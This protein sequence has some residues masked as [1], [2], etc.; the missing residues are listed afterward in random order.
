MTALVAVDVDPRFVQKLLQ[1]PVHAAGVQHD[2][3]VRAVAE[4]VAA[5]AFPLLRRVL[6]GS[7]RHPE[8]STRRRTPASAQ[9]CTRQAGPPGFQAGRNPGLTFGFEPLPIDQSRTGTLSRPARFN[10]TA[11]SSRRWKNAGLIAMRSLPV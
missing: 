9:P 5:D 6:R 1:N 3:R 7:R 8:E 4:D 2:G 10:A 11:F